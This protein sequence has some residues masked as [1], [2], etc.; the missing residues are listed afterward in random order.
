MEGGEGR[1]SEMNLQSDY[2]VYQRSSIHWNVQQKFKE[3]KEI[4][5][6][7]KKENIYYDGN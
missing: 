7:I 4:D 1:V 2:T 3:R 5:A 6:K